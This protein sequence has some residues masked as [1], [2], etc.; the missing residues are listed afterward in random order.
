M[1]LTAGL[2]ISS[3]F[4]GMQG[5][6]GTFASSM[7][8]KE[9]DLVIGIGVRFSDRVTGNAEKYAE[10]AKIIHIDADFAEIG[11]NIRVDCGLAGNIKTTVSRILAG[12][13]KAV[14]PKWGTKVSALREEGCRIQCEAEEKASDVL[15]PKKIFDVIN[16]PKS[17]DT[18][19]ATDVGQHQ[20]WTAQY[21]S[22]VRERTFASSGGLGTMGFGLGA[23]IGSAVGTKGRSILITGDGSFGMNLNEMATAV[24]YNLPVTVIL[25]NNEYLEWFVSGRRSSTESVTRTRS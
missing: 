13:T 23:A 22:F 9:A 3:R 18:V 6:H 7:A 21:A 4:L 16:A 1:G 25:L 10:H 11:K 2:G 5:M 15:T 20:M 12:C 19:I 24:S 8:N 17:P 14:H